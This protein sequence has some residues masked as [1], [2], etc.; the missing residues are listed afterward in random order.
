M[1]K[2]IACFCMLAFSLFGELQAKVKT[3]LSAQIYGY[4]GEMVYFDCAQSP[5]I[6]Q[7]FHSNPGEEHV[8]SFDTDKLVCMVINGKANILLEPG[9]SL[10]VNIQY[11]GRKVRSLDF[12]GTP[13]AVT[14]N[15]VLN[16]IGKLKVD[17]RYKTQLLGCAVL[18]IKPVKRIGDSK[19]LLDKVKAMVSN[20]E[21]KVSEAVANYLIAETEADAY[22]SYMEYPVM[23]SEIRKTPLEKLGI[24]DYWKIMDGYTVRTD[25]ASLRNMNYA[26]MLMRYCFYENEKK[27]VA[28]GKTYSIPQKFEGMYEEI[29]AFLDGNVRDF[30]LYRLICN[31]IQ[32]GQEIER[33]DALFNDYKKKYNKNPEYIQILETLL[34]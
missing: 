26:N 8:F 30:V 25:E 3:T 5:L 4:Q 9:D 13:A 28:E 14:H 21:N 6:S 19:I 7:E 34:Q 1:T 10:H 22:M 24:G 33:A 15:Q 11:E 29:A 2:F 20:P 23:Y 32:G 27:A 12:S 16:N 18:D 17:M 31:F